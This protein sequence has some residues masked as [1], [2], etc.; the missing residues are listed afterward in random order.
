MWSKSSK[1]ILLTYENMNI[2]WNEQ[3]YGENH[4]LD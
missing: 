1:G 2:K 4:T 3:D